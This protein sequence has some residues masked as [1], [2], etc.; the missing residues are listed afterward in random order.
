MTPF[1]IF[2]ENNINP[3]LN[4]KLPTELAVGR[5]GTIHLYFL[6]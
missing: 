4:I 5:E 3:F 6:N 1:Y 2:F